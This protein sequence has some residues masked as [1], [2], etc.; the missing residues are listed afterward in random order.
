[1]YMKDA[2]R[3]LADELGVPLSTELKSSVDDL[4]LMPAGVIAQAAVLL[5]RHG[6][7]TAVDYLSYVTTSANWDY[8]PNFLEDVVQK[9]QPVAAWRLGA[10][11]FYPKSDDLVAVARLRLAD[12]IR[13]LNGG[14]RS[15]YLYFDPT[16][17]HRDEAFGGAPGYVISPA[18]YRWQR[19]KTLAAVKWSLNGIVPPLLPVPDIAV[20]LARWLAARISSFAGGRKFANL[21]GLLALLGVAPG[22]VGDV[23][24]AG[25]RGLIREREQVGDVEAPPG[26]RGPDGWFVIPDGARR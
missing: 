9:G 16:G 20:S 25:I 21:D 17:A 19:S 5:E 14:D 10:V 15:G 22:E 8:L 2:W 7:L 24:M 1:M 4:N 26:F 11:F 18:G 13:Q 6:R 3:R 23:A 12:Y